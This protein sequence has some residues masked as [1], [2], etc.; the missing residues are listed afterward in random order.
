[1]KFGE[2]E[3]RLMITNKDGQGGKVVIIPKEK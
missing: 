2:R 1:M 3:A